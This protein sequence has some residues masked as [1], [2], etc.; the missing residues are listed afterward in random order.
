MASHGSHAGANPPGSWWGN[1]SVSGHEVAGHN[2]HRPQ[3]FVAGE[4]WQPSAQVWEQPA[5]GLAVPDSDPITP[6]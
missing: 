1:S 6:G 2:A 3:G 4:P 5:G